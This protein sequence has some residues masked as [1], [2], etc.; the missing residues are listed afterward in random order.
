MRLGL[1]P[2]ALLDL[3]DDIF[4]TMIDIMEGWDNGR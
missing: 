2:A 3:D 4:T 1:H